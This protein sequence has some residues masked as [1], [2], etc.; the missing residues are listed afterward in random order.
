MSTKKRLTLI[1]SYLLLTILSFVGVLFESVQPEKG[2]DILNPSQFYGVFA[3]ILFLL[4]SFYLFFSKKEELPFWLSFA[5]LA[6]VCFGIIEFLL[7]F[8]FAFPVFDPSND[9]WESFL[10]SDALYLGVF[11]PLLSVLCF[12][13]TPQKQTNI[14]LSSLLGVVLMFIY[15]LFALVGFL[16]LKCDFL[17]SLLVPYRS[18][19]KPSFFSDSFLGLCYPIYVF[20][21]LSCSYGFALLLEFSKREINLKKSKKNSKTDVI[22]EEN[23]AF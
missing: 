15:I 13:F 5:L 11:V 6:L 21:L 17:P 16:A 8:L 3:I 20:I 19:L 23:E 2:F 4:T 10:T 18:V 7:T 1:T 22:S 9:I 12:L 14:F